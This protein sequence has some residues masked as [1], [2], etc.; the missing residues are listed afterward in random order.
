VAQPVTDENAE[1]RAAEA[2]LARFMNRKE[3]V[4]V[5]SFD[6]QTG[7][8][9]TDASGNGF[10]AAPNQPVPVVTGG[11]RGKAARFSSNYCAARPLCSTR[12]KYGVALGQP[13]TCAAG[14][15][16]QQTVRGHRRAVGAFAA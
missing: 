2:K 12:R 11:V 16:D 1:Q 15:I 9:F 4:A 5:W 13:D 8:R 10:S 7:E 3:P 14:A 6:Q